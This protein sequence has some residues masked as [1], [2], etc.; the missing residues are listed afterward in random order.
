MGL[1]AYLESLRQYLSDLTVVDKGQPDANASAVEQG[2]GASELPV[3]GAGESGLVGADYRGIIEGSPAAGS[4]TDSV[5]PNDKGAEIVDYLQPEPAADAGDTVNTYHRALDTFQTV[6]FDDPNATDNSKM[7]AAEALYEAR[8]AV[9]KESGVAGLAAADDAYQPL[10]IDGPDNLN[11]LASNIL[12]DEGYEF[13]PPGQDVSDFVNNAVLNS[14]EGLGSPMGD[15]NRD[16]FL[17]S[18]SDIKAQHETNVA[19]YGEYYAKDLMNDTDLT[20]FERV[21]EMAE[22]QGRMDEALEAWNNRGDEKYP[23]DEAQA[24]RDV[25]AELQALTGRD[26]YQDSLL[27]GADADTY[28]SALEGSKDVLEGF[29][30][31]TPKVDVPNIYRN[32]ALVE[33][34]ADVGSEGV[35]DPALTKPLVANQ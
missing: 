7:L 3:D 25:H 10:D 21:I 19:L 32:P 35:A 18:L 20:Q 27:A 11:K 8:A 2:A 12:V 1:L 33:A 17:S 26:D 28:V 31:L 13:E 14:R 24:L 6:F 34:R 29:Y 9:L 16:E 22:L 15:A 30:D 5:A 23:I 4:E